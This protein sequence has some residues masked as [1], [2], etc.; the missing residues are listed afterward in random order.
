VHLNPSE[1]HTEINPSVLPFCRN[2]KIRAELK[3]VLPLLLLLLLL[4]LLKIFKKICVEFPFFP[5]QFM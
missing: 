1:K 3:N 2:V 4:L 5:I